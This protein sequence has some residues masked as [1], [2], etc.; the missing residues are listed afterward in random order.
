MPEQAQPNRP[1]A[2]TE[3]RKIIARDVNELLEG[4]GMLA[5]H[6]A[7]KRV[8]YSVVI[9]IMTDNP[10][11]PGGGWKTETR[12][13]PA[14]KAQIAET[15]GVEAIE[16]F[17]LTGEQSEDHLESGVERK[18]EIIS[19][20]VS[21]IMNGLPITVTSRGP[22]GEVKEHQVTYEDETLPEDLEGLADVVT[23]KELTPE[24][25]VAVPE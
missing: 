18:R 10:M 14:T 19:P 24:E 22:D 17:P 7:Y 12:S 16:T 4:D 13:R 3:L 15:V 6:I 11:L 5:G 23:D 2:G 8:S 1:L 9:K 25:T 20:N 21:R